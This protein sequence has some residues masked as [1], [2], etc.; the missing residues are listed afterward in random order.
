MIFPYEGYTEALDRRRNER[1]SKVDIVYTVENFEGVNTGAYI[2]TLV[3]NTTNFITGILVSNAGA[4][5]GNWEIQ[6]PAI[7]NLSAAIFAGYLAPGASVWIS[8][9]GI[10]A[11]Y[12]APVLI[13]HTFGAGNA[14]GCI[15]RFRENV[16][17]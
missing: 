2:G 1:D 8:N 13:N 17:V 9:G 6:V 14:Y 16:Q 5:G 4:L 7:E 3:V 15:S 12:K 11:V 10:L